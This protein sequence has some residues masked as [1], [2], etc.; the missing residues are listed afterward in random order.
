MNSIW[1]VYINV[2]QRPISYHRTLVGAKTYVERN[3]VK[4]IV[5]WQDNVKDGEVVLSKSTGF[6]VARMDMKP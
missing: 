4:N 6:T 5:K 1:I 2:G 3:L